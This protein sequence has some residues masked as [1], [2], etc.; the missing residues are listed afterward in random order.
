MWL[1]GGP[2]LPICIQLLSEE[3][4]T[5]D[6]RFELGE[7]PLARQVLHPAIRRDDEPLGSY[8]RERLADPVCDDVRRLDLA[9]AQ[10][11]DSEND[12]LVGE[13]PQHLRV[14]TRLCRLERDV[15]RE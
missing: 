7:R 3:L 4:R 9:R 2:L 13:V 1:T 10:V 15:R 6:H 5:C 8:N 12:R 14:E 11:E